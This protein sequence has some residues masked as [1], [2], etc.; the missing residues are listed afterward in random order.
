[1]PEPTVII[2]AVISITTKA[3]TTTTNALN[4]LEHLE[5]IVAESGSLRASLGDAQDILERIRR[6]YSNALDT[7]GAEVATHTTLEKKIQACRISC[8]KINTI[9]TEVRTPTYKPFKLNKART[10]RANLLRRISKSL[11]GLCIV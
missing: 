5:E 3:I 7:I 11:T 1:M 6:I 4:S 9:L 8:E 2:S 10:E